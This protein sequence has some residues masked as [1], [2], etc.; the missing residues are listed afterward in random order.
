MQYK[1]KVFLV[2]GLA[3]SGIAAAKLLL[4]LKASVILYDRDENVYKKQEVIALLECGAQIYDGT[5]GF[6][7]AV[8]SPGVPI[9]DD[10]LVSI[11]RGGGKIIGELELG[12]LLLS[13]PI[14]AVTGTNGKTTVTTMLT[15]VLKSCGESAFSLGNVG[16]PITEK[17]TALKPTDFAVVEASSFQLET[18]KAFCPHIAVITN[19]TQD[20]LDRHY[21]MENYVF[22]KGQILK[23]M[24]SSEFAV[25]NYDD[26]TVR[27]FA[28]KTNAKVI[29]FS[30]KDWA[31]SEYQ[32]FNGGSD[33]KCFD[34]AYFDG[35]FLCFRGERVIDANALNVYGRH[36]IENAL[37]VIS[38][39]WAAGKSLD[40]IKQG[41]ETFRGTNHRLERVFEC[42]NVTYYNDSK[43]TN[44]GASITAVDCMD[45]NT[46][47]IL[48]GETKSQDFKPLFDK[49]KNSNVT[50]AIIVGSGKGELIK[51]AVDNDYFSF[52]VARDLSDAVRL[53]KSHLSGGGGNVLLSPACSSLDQ[54]KNY[55]ERGQ[56]FID[57]VKAL[58]EA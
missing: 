16:T 58:Y 50:L 54:Y 27:A 51:C 9:D 7:A 46:V 30:F 26:K 14:I 28:E 4:S 32:A 23:N 11:K 56:A 1:N 55:E 29:W 17:A 25:L 19:I 42:D 8:V 20:H 49:L 15:H 48:G 35:Q 22:L 13:A 43:A 37:A 24:T 57:A 44:V 33:G 12:S 45:K 53:A 38:A 31:L 21:S 2:Y 5:Q 6:Y 41:L 39:C 34:G 47:I 3:K 36:N 10:F 18:I 40:D 52:Y